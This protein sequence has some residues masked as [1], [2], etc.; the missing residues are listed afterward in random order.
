MARFP[1]L[2]TFLISTSCATMPAAPSL[3]PRPIESA[4]TTP[5]VPAPT[6]AAC[7]DTGSETRINALIAQARAADTR[8][9]ALLSKA[10]TSAPVGSDAWLDAQNARSAAALEQSATLA[11][12]AAL[13]E[14]IAAR[15]E[16]CNI[17]AYQRAQDEVEAIVTRQSAAFSR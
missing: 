2:L 7:A 6:P 17:S 8:F 15:I 9:A 5:D 11:V 16:T 4:T 3:A 1:V 13:D 14:A 10:R 12:M